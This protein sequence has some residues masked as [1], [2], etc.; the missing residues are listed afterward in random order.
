MKHV[1]RAGDNFPEPG[2][3]DPNT[4]LKYQRSPIAFINP[5][6][7]Q[8]SP[9][10]TP[11]PGDYNPDYNLVHLAS[12]VANIAPGSERPNQVSKDLMMSPGPG[13]YDPKDPNA[14][15]SYTIGY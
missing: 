14:P 2:R 7:V 10:L 12:P 5:E 6:G 13:K 1:D 15:I 4:E 9:F 11:G 8:P 3:Y